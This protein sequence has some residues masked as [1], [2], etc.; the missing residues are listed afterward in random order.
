VKLTPADKHFGKCIKERVNWTC[1][2][3][4]KHYPDG[5]Q[6][7]HCSHF[8]G[9][10]KQSVRYEPLNAYAH[11]HGCHSHFSQYPY[12]FDKWVQKKLGS[13]YDIL[14]EKAY[15]IPLGKEI[16]RTKGKGEISKH[17][18]SEFERMQKLRADGERGRIE[19]VGWL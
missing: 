10:V 4:G 12:E 13:S 14:V 9:R 17:F 15:D 16:A 11:C 18:K 7:L 5:G 8:F 19:F 3:C 6:G 1:E 2:R